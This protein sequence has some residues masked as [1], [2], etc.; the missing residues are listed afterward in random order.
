MNPNMP[1][2]PPAS[3]SAAELRRRLLASTPPPAAGPEAPAKGSS[4]LNMGDVLSKLRM[5]GQSGAS[6]PPPVM[7]DVAPEPAAYSPAATIN[8]R[9]PV[10]RGSLD[11]GG[12]SFGISLMSPSTFVVPPR[13][14]W[15][16]PRPARPRHLLPLPNP[17]AADRPAWTRPSPG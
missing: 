8:R 10:A 2:D 9:P 16:R 17:A 4:S 11:V 13:A 1:P 14:G 15:N 6:P 7:P 3:I 12:S 5:P